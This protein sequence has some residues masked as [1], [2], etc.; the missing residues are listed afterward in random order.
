MTHPMKKFKCLKCGNCCTIEGSV[1]LRSGEENL[2]AAHLRI[3]V[4]EL[5][6][7]YTDI[8]PD[9]GAL[10][11]KDSEDGSCIFLGAD[12]RCIINDAKPKQCGSFPFQWN[13]S[14]WKKVC[15]T[16]YPGQS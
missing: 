8:T 15:S 1:R 16:N 9:R 6:Q 14:G 11:L 10:Q 3:S 13:Y 2:I 5:V 7:K 4:H 12:R